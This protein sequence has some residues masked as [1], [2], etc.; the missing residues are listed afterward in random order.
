MS[1]LIGVNTLVF[2]DEL[3][4][5]IKKQ[6]E[7]FNEL[8]SMKV[9]FVEIR[10]EYIRDFSS[11][12]T[13]TAEKAEKLNLILF[14]SVPSSLF[15]SGEINKNLEMYLEEAHIL[16]SKHLKLI[17]G[18]F[19]DF[20]ELIVAE[21]KNI[22]NKYP[23]M[24]LSIENDQSKKGGSAESLSIFIM[25]A[26]KYEIPLSVTFDTG[27]FIYIGEVPEQAAMILADFVDFIH[28]KNVEI[29]KDGSI[30]LTLFDKGDINM[31]TVLHAFP[32][33]IIAAIEYPCGEKNEAMK[34]LGRQLK[35]IRES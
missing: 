1:R 5:G 3:D 18:D 27:N 30:Q 9:P 23:E 26:H 7:Y 2:K 21:L 16:K 15:V 24:K 33:N 29:Q 17:L 13:H 22:L 11:E 8:D 10:R 20:N 31:S 12:L 19:T 35:R 34:E 25:N 14:Y 4:E 28:I 6:W 32:N